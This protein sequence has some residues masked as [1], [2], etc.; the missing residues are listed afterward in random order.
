M[1]V[2]YSFANEFPIEVGDRLLVENAS[3][4]VGSTGLGY[5]SEAYQFRTFEV[6]QVHQN[7]GNVGIVTYSMGVMFHLE[8]YLVTLMLRYHLQY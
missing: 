6:T 2:A 1:K 3:V 4:G 8:K 7:L 5:N